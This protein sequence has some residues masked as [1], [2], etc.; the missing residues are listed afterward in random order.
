MRSLV[1]PL[2]AIMVLILAGT[3]FSLALGRSVTL[4]QDGGPLT[5][6]V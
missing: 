2:S 3:T 1:R 6:A 4:A 5:A